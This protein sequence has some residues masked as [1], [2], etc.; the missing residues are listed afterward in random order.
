MGSCG[1][2]LSGLS[3]RAVREERECW[4]AFAPGH[5]DFC[6][7]ARGNGFVSLLTRKWLGFAALRYA[8]LAMTPW[9]WAVA[10]SF[11]AGR[12]V[13]TRSAKFG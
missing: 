7:A 6:I 10:F 3:L 5:D 1:G 8:A 2:Q 11:R 9:F 12:P 4:V 13:A